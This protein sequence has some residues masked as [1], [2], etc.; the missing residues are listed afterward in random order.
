MFDSIQ[1]IQQRLAEETSFDLQ[2]LKTD[3]L[4]A[5]VTQGDN[6]ALMNIFYANIGKNIAG[7]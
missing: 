5:S 6:D 7:Q 1:E 4:T 2:K 3:S